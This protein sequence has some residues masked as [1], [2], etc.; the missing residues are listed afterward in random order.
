[1]HAQFIMIGFADQFDSFIVLH[2][3]IHTFTLLPSFLAKKDYLTSTLTENA[4]I[5][6]N[7]ETSTLPMHSQT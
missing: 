2:V 3:P 7:E 6:A 1:M 4:A 5:M